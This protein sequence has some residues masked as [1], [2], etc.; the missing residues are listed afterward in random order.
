M[1]FLPSSFTADAR[2]LVLTEEEAVRQREI[3]AKRERAARDMVE[4]FFGLSG[5]SKQG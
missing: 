4:R 5:Q 1:A 2:G 3:E